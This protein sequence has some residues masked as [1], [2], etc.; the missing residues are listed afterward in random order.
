MMHVL[1]A[2]RCDP[3]LAEAELAVRNRRE[4]FKLYRQYL[5]MPV[6]SGRRDRSL[7]AGY[8]YICTTTVIVDHVE[9]CV[10][11]PFSLTTVFFFNMV[12][13]Q[14][15]KISCSTLELYLSKNMHTINTIFN[16][17]PLFAGSGKP[18]SGCCRRKQAANQ[19][20]LWLRR[21]HQLF[22]EPQKQSHGGPRRRNRKNSAGPLLPNHT[23]PSPVARREVRAFPTSQKR[24]NGS[25]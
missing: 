3:F 18:S 4:G 9:R 13:L 25:D 2:P 24:R 22:G 20:Y 10:T 14:I 19:P 8:I 7:Q 11:L 6:T 23:P 17:T 1:F 12:C 5:M 21:P 15:M 16:C